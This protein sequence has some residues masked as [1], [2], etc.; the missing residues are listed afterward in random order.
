VCVRSLHPVFSPSRS[1]ATSAPLGTDAQAVGTTQIVVLGATLG[2][3]LTVFISC[4]CWWSC[5][6]R[7]SRAA[8]D[9]ATNAAAHAAAVKAAAA[10]AAL[11]HTGWQWVR[12]APM[13][14]A[15]PAATTRARRPQQQRATKHGS[16][17]QQSSASSRV[18]LQNW[19][20]DDAFE[21][22]AHPRRPAESTIV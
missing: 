16:S 7:R 4:V 22:A 5:R 21:D 15:A 2:F 6:Y 9:A 10:A 11:P 12:E 1:L 19:I 8:A 17:G 20:G 13:A 14:A 3:C 18:R